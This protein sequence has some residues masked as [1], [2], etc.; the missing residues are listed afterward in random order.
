MIVYLL[1]NGLELNCALTPIEFCTI[2]D[3]SDRGDVSVKISV[4]RGERVGFIPIEDIDTKRT[5]EAL[6]VIPN[7]LPLEL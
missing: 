1:A 6:Q 3:L 4:T 2:V 7:Q 5:M